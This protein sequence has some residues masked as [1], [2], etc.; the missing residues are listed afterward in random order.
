MAVTRD[1]EELADLQ[2]AAI[3]R[4]VGRLRGMTLGEVVDRHCTVTCR[5]CEVTRPPAGTAYAPRHIFSLES[6]V[7]ALAAE[8]LENEDE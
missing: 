6:I 4:E 8:N 2:E 1:P 7:W 5:L 3:E